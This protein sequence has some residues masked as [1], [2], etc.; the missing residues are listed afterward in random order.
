MQGYDATVLALGAL[1]PRDLRAPG[2]DLNGIHFAMPYLTMQN[3]RNAGDHIPDEEF[4]SAHGKH[5]VILGGGD[6]G[7]DCLGTAHR[8]GAKSVTQLQYRPAPP[9]ARTPDNPWPEWGYIYRTSPAHEEGGAREYSVSTRAFLGDEHGRVRAIKAVRTE[10]RVGE[11][12][13]SRLVELHGTEHEIPADLVLL[14]IGFAGPE[15]NTVVDELGVELTERGNIAMDRNKMTSVPGVFV[16]G[17]AER[18]ASLVVWAIADGRRTAQQADR[19]LMGTT[20][21]SGS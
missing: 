11:D 7:A 4:I 5:V 21:L 3:K 2:R 17:D 6:T 15:T 12:G 20:Q 16:A 14:A 10:V 9:E 13:R 1:K 18:G 19:Y 8:Q